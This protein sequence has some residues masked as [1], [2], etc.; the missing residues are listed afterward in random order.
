MLSSSS[1]IKS[2]ISSIITLSSSLINVISWELAVATTS[3]KTVIRTESSKNIIS[4]ITRL[5]NVMLKILSLI[6]TANLYTK[7]LKSITRTLIQL[8][9]E[10]ST[11]ST[12]ICCSMWVEII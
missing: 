10:E 7:R 8:E 11:C 3:Y 2:I 12:T 6:I 5:E 1:S 4:L 9:S